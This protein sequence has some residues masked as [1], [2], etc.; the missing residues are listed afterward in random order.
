M[1]GLFPPA[2]VTDRVDSKTYSCARSDHSAFTNTDTKI[3]CTMFSRNRSS[4]FL[5]VVNLKR[6]TRKMQTVAT[7]DLP[8]RASGF[9]RAV[10]RF[11][12]GKPP[13]FFRSKTNCLPWESRHQTNSSYTNWSSCWR[14]AS[15][16]TWLVGSVGET[17]LSAIAPVTHPCA[18]IAFSLMCGLAIDFST[19]RQ[20]TLSTSYQHPYT[21]LSLVQIGSNYHLDSCK[22]YP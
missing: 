8:K 12:W 22:I 5:Q 15:W 9:K 16:V 7:P 21:D 17:C 10:E 2:S 18:L 6:Y 13:R 20:W 1:F 14:K 19:L 3:S 11:C 4:N